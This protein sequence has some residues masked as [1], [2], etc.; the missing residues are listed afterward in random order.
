VFEGVPYACKVVSVTKAQQKEVMSEVRVS[1]R[2]KGCRRLVA[3]RGAYV[4]P[5]DVLLLTEF[6]CTPPFRCLSIMSVMCSFF[7][8]I[9]L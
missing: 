4:S 7:C 1:R 8:S 3:F 2:L 6:C 9:A 5:Q